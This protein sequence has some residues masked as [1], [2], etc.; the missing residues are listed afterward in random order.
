LFPLPVTYDS[1]GNT[2]KEDIKDPQGTLTKTVSYQYDILGRLYRVNNPDTNY[3]E[4][5]YDALGRQSSYK[6][7]KNNPL[8]YYD[9]DPLHRLR[10]VTQ[11]GN[12]QTLY[13][14]DSHNNLVAVTDGNGNTTSYA[15]DDMHRVYQEI[16]PD[17]GTTAYEYDPEGNVVAK[18]DARGIRIVYQYDALNRLA[19]TNFPSPTET[20]ISYAF[21]NC[22]NGKGRLCQ[23]I[24][25]TGTTTYVY[26]PKGK[27]VQEDKLVLGVNY[28]T[29]YQYD[30]NGNV[31]VLTYPSGRTVT[32]VYDNANQVTSVLTTPS[33][34]AQQTVASSISYY[35]FGSVKS[36][37]HGNGLVRTVDHDLQYRVTGIQTGTI[38]DLT[39]VPDPN[40]NL[41][42]IINNLDVNK[43]KGF[44]YDALDRLE[45]ATGPWG[46]LAWTYDSVGN[47]QSQT[48]TSGTAIFTYYTGTNRLESLS[49]A[50]TSSFT[51]DADGNTETEDSRQFIYNENNRLVQVTDGLVLAEYTYNYAGQRVTKTRQGQTTIFHYALWR[52]LLSETV[53]TAF[54]D[55]I[56][57]YYQPIAKGTGTET[58]FVHTDHLATPRAMT[59]LSQ[60]TVWNLDA[61]PFGDEQTIEGDEALNIRFPGQYYD[62]ETG[63]SY[64]DFRDYD[65][66]LGRYVESDPIGLVGGINPYTYARA[67]PIVAFDPTG[68]AVPVVAAWL[69][70]GG[71]A[72]ILA[73]GG[74][75]AT[76]AGIGIM[77]GEEYDPPIDIFPPRKKPPSQ[78]PPDA[79]PAPNAPP[80]TAP[81]PEEV[82]PKPAATPATPETIET[83]GDPWMPPDIC[84]KQPE[85]PCELVIKLCL[86][87]RKW[88]MCLIAILLCLTPDLGGSGPGPT[89]G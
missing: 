86:A 77:L 66:E 35:P 67:N 5:T 13:S 36:M 78:S 6:D 74:T 11:P 71:G 65:P 59:D 15:F 53:G 10:E 40:G 57:L 27:L 55:F 4:Y 60:T 69:M 54:N 34:G 45:S 18:T 70:A 2:L 33:S 76:L 38:Q 43:N 48:D 1:S 72:K 73:W 7:P 12:I 75:F 80:R 51:Y 47:R 52:S 64:N 88:R 20:D 81:T 22:I 49:G 39:Y 8:T 17:T 83:V 50:K 16:S 24:D 31:E 30:E 89:F 44:T 14:Y 26:S 58:H 28:T 85:N 82:V 63:L 32:Y 9:Y 42:S 68:K 41:Q 46:T 19:L 56:Y 3:W 37:T 21:D 25:Q 29:E 23:V 61:R 62:E 79:E 87:E 84:E